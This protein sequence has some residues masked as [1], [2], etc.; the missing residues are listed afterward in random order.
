MKQPLAAGETTT[1]LG[2]HI[3]KEGDKLAYSITEEAWDDLRTK[4][5]KARTR[6]GRK[7]YPRKFIIRGWLESY[8]PALGV[9]SRRATAIRVQEE[10]IQVE[11]EYLD[12]GEILEWCDKAWSRYEETRKKVKEQIIPRGDEPK[13]EGN[14]DR[15]AAPPARIQARIVPPSASTPDKPSEPSHFGSPTRD[16]FPEQDNHSAHGQQSPPSAI[17]APVRSA[18]E[19]LS[20]PG[21][22][23]ILPR[24]RRPAEGPRGQ[25]QS[26]RPPPCDG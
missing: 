24:V 8:G 3:R 19:R 25:V 2:F 15:A 26:A 20:P 17:A 9:N 14:P 5:K 16:P 18:L 22:G 10:M 7:S 1:W 11:G 23:V 13:P 21:E 12:L 4:L 6:N